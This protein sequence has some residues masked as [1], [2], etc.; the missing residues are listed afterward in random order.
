MSKR[1]WIVPILLLLLV[2]V[3]GTYGAAWLLMPSRTDYGATWETYRQEPRNSV[4]VLYFGSSLVYCNVV[5]SVIWEESGITSYVMAGPEQ[6]I[7]ISYYYIRETCRTQNPKA[8]VL[9]V[10]GLFYPEHGGF[11]KANISYMPW[12]VNRIAATFKAAEKELRTSLLFPILDYHSLWT[13]VRGGQ[14]K[15]H[16]SPGTDVF[17]GYT[18]LEKVT[19]QTETVVRG[20]RA[21]TENYARN[22]EYL[23]EIYEYCEKRDIQL[24]L[25]VTPTK[26]RIADDAYAQMRTDVAKLT[27][28]V[29]VDFND[30][31]AELGID[32]STDWF[33][34]IHFNCRGAE[35]FSRY[36]GAFL[37][38]EIG[39]S[40]TEG[41]NESLWQGRVDEFSGRRD[42]LDR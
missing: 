14:I 1:K 23:R 40:A 37:R 9:E 7:P 33:D 12:S 30:N 2:F 38:N 27:N 10:T 41:E 32:D 15:Q 17:A 39:L 31:M 34:F 13:S 19:P 3:L 4:D 36:L 42:A 21:N 24:V 6:T 11:T 35:K 16:L 5:P 25:M 18:Y 22:L 8:I 29:F 26:G 28:A 20:Y